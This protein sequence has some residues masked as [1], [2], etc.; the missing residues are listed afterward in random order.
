MEIR[1]GHIQGLIEGPAP[2]SGAVF[3]MLE[4]AGNGK[5]L[6]LEEAATLLNVTDPALLG[7]IYEKAGSVK[8][9]VFGKRVVLFAPLYLSNY[10]SNG[11]VYCGFRSSNKDAVRKALD[12]EDVVAEARAL[13]GMGFKRVLLV[14]GED[15]Q[16][17]LDYIIA[18]IRAIYRSTGIRIVHVNCP[19]MDTDGMRELKKAGAGVYQSFQETYHRKSYEEAHPYGNKKDYQHRLDCMDRAFDAGFEDVGIGPLFGLYDYRFDA[20]AAIAHSKHLYKRYGAHAHTISIPRLRPASGWLLNKVPHPVSDEEIKKTVAVFRLSVPAA[21]VVVSTR[22]E[23][24]LRN[25]LMRAGASQMSAASSTSPGN[26]MGKDSSAPQFETSDKRSLAEVIQSIVEEGF[27]PSLCTSCYRAG[28]VGREFAEK[29]A[30][31][32]MSKFCQANAILTLR[33]Y[34]YGSCKNGS[35]DMLEKA[36]LAALAEVKDPSMKKAIEEK[37][38]KLEQG[39]R[40]IYF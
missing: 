28:R 36:V 22:E 7:E 5:G 15:P 3:S 32:E 17:G 6:L 20:L 25:I 35:K 18:S 40:D 33:E 21:G 37:L 1:E 4:K 10:C 8:E 12:E 27:L 16:R 9:R 38:E 19:P 2:S 30:A 24:G 29:T 34:I 13:E 14:T 39:Q 11:C 23:A 26:Y 31:G